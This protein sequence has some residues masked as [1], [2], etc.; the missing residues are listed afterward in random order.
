MADL[1]NALNEKLNDVMVPGFEADFAPGEAE[2]AGCFREDA[3]SAQDAT[4]SSIDQ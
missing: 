2:E 4:D 1:Q 3:L